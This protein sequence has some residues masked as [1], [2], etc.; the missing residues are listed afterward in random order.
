V[1]VYVIPPVWP[2]SKGYWKNH[3]ENWTVDEVEV[4]NVTHSKNEAIN[5]LK[6]ANSKDATCMLSAQLITAKLSRKCGATSVFVYGHKKVNVDTVIVNVNV[7][8][9]HYPLGMDPQGNARQEALS[10][11]DLLDANNSQ[12]E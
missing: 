11:K 9:G 5:I 8:L 3:P 7:F 4:G 1:N 12:G 6:N 2:R 10:L